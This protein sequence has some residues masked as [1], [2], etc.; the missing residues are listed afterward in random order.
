MV[1]GSSERFSTSAEF[2]VACGLSTTAV[3]GDGSPRLTLWLHGV[4][5]GL[6]GSNDFTEVR[7]EPDKWLKVFPTDGSSRTVEMSVW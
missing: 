7:Q 6:F 3:S 1:S 4:A 5:E 2:A